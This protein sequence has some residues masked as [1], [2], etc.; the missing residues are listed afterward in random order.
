MLKVFL[1][2]LIKILAPCLLDTALN[3]KLP[4][5]HHVDFHP[6]AQWSGS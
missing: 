6:H 2:Y 5:E 4:E 3:K 1:G